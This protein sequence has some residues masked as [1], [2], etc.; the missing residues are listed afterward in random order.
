MVYHMP[1]SPCHSPKHRESSRSALL[2]ARTILKEL[3]LH[4]NAFLDMKGIACLPSLKRS[5]QSFITVFLGT[6]GH[7]ECI[8]CIYLKE[9]IVKYYQIKKGKLT[10]M[11]SASFFVHL[12]IFH[13]S[14][15]ASIYEDF[16]SCRSHQVGVFHDSLLYLAHNCV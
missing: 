14:L 7:M 3:N 2:L 13:H 9:D 15:L 5:Y 11:Y 10:V 6:V 12:W 8:Q 16:Q 4:L 1:F